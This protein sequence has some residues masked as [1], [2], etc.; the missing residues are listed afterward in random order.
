MEAYSKIN[1]FLIRVQKSC[2][3]IRLILGAY[4]FS[5]SLLGI[6]LCVALFYYL[7]PSAISYYASILLFLI[8]GKYVYSTARS[9]SLNKIDR[10]GAAL[11]T[12]KKYPE[13]NNS[14]INSAQL[15]ELVSD[16]A[17]EKIFSSAFICEL[18]ARTQNHLTKL[19]ANSVIEKN[20]TTR[21]RNLFLSTLA[22]GLVATF[23]VPDFWQQALKNSYASINPLQTIAAEKNISRPELAE[24]VYSIDELALTL[25]YPA[26]TRLS[27]KKI[28]PS[29]GSVKALPGTE[30]LIKGK[31]NQAVQTASLVVNEKDSFLMESKKDSSLSGSFMIREKGFYQFRVKGLSGSR[32]VLPQRFPIELEKD[33]KPRILLF[34]A[35]PKPVYFDTDKIQI[36]YEGSDDFGIRSIE[37]VAQIEDSAIRKNIKSLKNGE[38]ASQGRFTWNLALESLKPGQEIQYYLEIKDNDNVSGPNINQSEMISF[39]IFD[40]RKEQENLVRLQ[41]ELTEKMI[42]LLATG[43]VEDNILKKTTKDALYGKKLLASNADALIDIIGLA[44]H[45][46]IQA[47]ELGSFPQ[48]YL[49]LLNN[50]ISGLNTIR[51]EKIDAID[52]IQGTI[53]KPTPVDYNLFSIEVLNDRMVTHLER[54]ILYLIKITN[55]QK[56]DRVMDLENQLS[57]LTEA[58][59]EEFKN[60][61]N[62]K[63][64]L[65]A[66]KL[67]S[68]LDQI[69]KTL[70][71]LM[72][73]LEQQNQSMPDEFLNSKS[74]KNM[75]LEK[76]MASIE[77]IQDLA[78]QGKMDEAM[79]Q[80][81]K[82]AEELRKFAE[83]LDQAE[84]SMEE[85][86]DTEMM[87]QLNESTLELKDMEKKQ[88][89][90]IKKTSKINQELRQKQSKKFESLVK[91]F[92]EEIK[93]DVD[94]IRAIL[95]NDKNYLNEHSAMKKLSKL[96]EKESILNQEIQSLGQ[97]TIDSSLKESLATNFAQLK[98]RQ[99]QLSS[100]LS[101]MSS[102]RAM[103][104]Q[105][106]K[107]KLPELQKKYDSLK[108]LAELSEL[109]EFN[110]LFKNTY[111]EIFRW[112]GNMQASRNE[113]IGGKIRDDLKQV[114][115][116]NGEISKKLGSLKRSIETSNDSLLPKEAKSQLKKMAQ[117]EKSMQGKAEGMQKQ[118][119]EMNQRNPLLPPSLAQNMQ[120]AGKNLQRA[121]SRLQGSQVQ[122][123]IESENKALKQ[124]Q[125]AQSMLSEMKKSGS[126][127]SQ[128]GKQ[129][130]Q[131][132][133][134]TGS[135][136]DSRPGGAMR[137]QKEK[138]LLPSDDQY[139]V[140][141]EF[142]EDIL[143]AMKKQTPKNYEQ[144]VNEYYRELVQ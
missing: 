47:E 62:K 72:K 89:E 77:K 84:S 29:N 122:R 131:L 27:A 139:K 105:E 112:Q 70:K 26:Y 35:N 34:P 7:Q 37:L 13:L 31:I 73:K 123:S 15:G 32:I 113:D 74:Y 55:R 75:N 98:D 53:M 130:N 115:R 1:Q 87:E 69:E 124:I 91:K 136:R 140:P 41:D 50:I 103:G 127:M 81:K 83:Q 63:S 4:L 99:R 21:S 51:Q 129:Q 144:L 137:M 14:L 104:L 88:R 93:K 121:E 46:K 85:M 125:E 10:E 108:E 142:R 126:Q 100:T 54:D 141:S 96:L 68:K 5:T 42:A 23:I 86:V 9:S 44:Q 18:L 16:P 28:N 76:M 97:E 128:Q 116:L 79:E 95:D 58:L 49:T 67:K 80:L 2:N 117:Q 45:I 57:E 110:L 22:L 65:D 61:K 24:P 20:R 3:R 119:S 11:L 56:M 6:L 133:L 30:V 90:I 134:G 94:S 12:E 114:N 25:N 33:Q 40:T 101:E 143:D 106:F 138:V 118:F 48:A 36:F 66:N 39:T 102:L 78:N 59:Q 38:K 92:F 43:L 107:E 71:Q 8:I 135:R 82:M 19:N 120:M 52:K 60:L 132:Q 111:P 109:N 17:K 64:P